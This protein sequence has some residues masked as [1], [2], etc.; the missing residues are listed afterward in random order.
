[1]KLTNLYI[2]YMAKTY[3]GKFTP[4]NKDKYKGDHTKIVYRS[5]WERQA[6]RWCDSSPRVIAWSS[7]EVVVPY[8]YQVDNKM[9]RYYVDLLVKFT[10]GSV[11]LVE[12]KPK[13]ET[14]A[15]KVPKRKTKRYLEEV[16]T[17]IKNTNKWQ[18]ADAYAKK[19][20]WKFEV[21]HEDTLK[22]MGIKIIKG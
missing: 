20:G 22:S 15:P 21:W 8:L 14:M 19:R 6:F 11:V 16:T 10:D 9:H 7:E 3:K 1:M 2:I 17:Y 18:A 5:L 4:K 13:K 12:I